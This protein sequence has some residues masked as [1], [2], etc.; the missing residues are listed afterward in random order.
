V[1]FENLY[2]TTTYLGV[3]GVGLYSIAYNHF[4]INFPHHRNRMC[5]WKNFENQSIFDDDM[6]KS[7]RV[8]YLGHPVLAYA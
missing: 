5:R 4:I 1:I 7:L 3:N 6:H 2:V 8:T